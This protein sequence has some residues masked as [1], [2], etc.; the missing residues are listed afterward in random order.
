MQIKVKKKKKQNNK[1]N[2]KKNIIKTVNDSKRKI[3]NKNF[4]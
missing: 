1:V 2:L 4:S 3:R